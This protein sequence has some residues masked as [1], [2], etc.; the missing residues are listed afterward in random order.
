VNNKYENPYI[1]GVYQCCG[2]QPMLRLYPKFIGDTEIPY[3]RYQCRVCGDIG[4]LSLN[5]QEAAAYFPYIRR[6]I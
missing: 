1:N 4:A 2:Q 6:T 5:E 3:V